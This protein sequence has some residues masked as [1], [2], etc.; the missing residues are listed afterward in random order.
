MATW[1]V[2]RG[3]KGFPVMNNSILLQIYI[4]VSQPQT[5]KIQEKI[6]FVSVQTALSCLNFYLISPKKIH[7]D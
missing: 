4:K 7:P 3:N 1:L 2:A 5:Y 6:N